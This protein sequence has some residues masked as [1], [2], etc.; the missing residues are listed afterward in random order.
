MHRRHPV[1]G[2]PVTHK[3]KGQVIDGNT[4][5]EWSTQCDEVTELK[6]IHTQ[7]TSSLYHWQKG[8][9]PKQYQFPRGFSPVILTPEIK[10]K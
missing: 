8:T 5:W 9:Y 10:T 4:S 7:P 1:A 3:V 2:E 6:G